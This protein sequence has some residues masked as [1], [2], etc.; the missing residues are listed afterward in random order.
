MHMNPSMARADLV[1]SWFKSFAVIL[2]CFFV[3][4]AVFKFINAARRRAR[5]RKKLARAARKE[6]KRRAGLDK[7][8]LKEL[9]PG[10]TDVIS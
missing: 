10:Q 7:G 4:Y 8:G 3:I 5:Y 9:L 1:I 6:A 2:L